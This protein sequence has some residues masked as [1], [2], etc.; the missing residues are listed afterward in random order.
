MD[1]TRERCKKILDAGANVILCSKGIDDFALKY[2]VE[3]KTI[4][5]RRVPKGDLRRIANSTGAKVVISLADYEGGEESYDPS[6]LGECTDVYEERVGDWE[7]MFFKGM[8]QTRAQ[9]IVI[10]GANDF[11]I[12]EIERSLH[13]S[14]CVIKRVLESNNL[15]AGGGAAEV[16]LSIY[17]DDFARTLGTREQLAIAE[18]SEALL[19]IPKTLAINAAKDATDLIAK[20]RVFHNAA[21]K[22]DDDQKK[23]LKHSGLDLVNGKVRNNLTAGVLEPSMS[24]VKSLKFATEA[25]ITILR[26]DDMIK[27][28]KQEQEQPRR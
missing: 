10:R 26:I 25:A 15:V 17:L 13:D 6:N 22:S 20:L 3:M 24:K 11:F 18:F 16:A 9:T 19:V 5:I 4:A 28:E 2:F 1:V 27:L 14:L 7:Y 21:Q 12:E 23:E 8:K